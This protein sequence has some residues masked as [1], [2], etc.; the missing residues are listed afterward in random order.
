MGVVPHFGNSASGMIDLT[1]AETP[2]NPAPPGGRCF[3]VD[4]ADGL[5]LRAVVWEASATKGTT[6]VYPGRTEPIELYFPV[7]RFLLSLGWSVAA[8]DWRGQGRSTRVL[9]DPRKGHVTSFLEYQQDAA[10]LLAAPG[11]A[12]LPRP[13]VLVCHSMGSAIAIRQLSAQPDAAD[14][15]VLCAP[16]LQLRFGRVGNL[17]LCGFAR[18]ISGMGGGNRHA[19]IR[20]G[21]SVAQMGFPGNPLTGSPERF[22]VL[23]EIEETIPG[24]AIGG[25]SWAWLRAWYRDG[26]ELRRLPPP[27][28]PVLLLV[29][30]RDRVVAPG[31]VVEF[32]RRTAKSRLLVLEEGEHSLLIERDGIRD[33]VLK[34]IAGFL[35]TFA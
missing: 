27:T 7:I 24:L 11:I 4:T 35:Q 3:A 30:A 22:A 32:A 21:T 2:S 9:P 16:L 14:A 29:S 8:V 5:V 6:I 18:L 1:L 26:A 25:P 20:G 34:E 31:P 28:V 33:P 17:L 12:A 13:R 10:A 15:M 19:S 23:Q